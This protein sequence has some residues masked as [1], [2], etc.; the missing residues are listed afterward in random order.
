ME[1][2]PKVNYRPHTLNIIVNTSIDNNI[3]N[4]MEWLPK[5]NYRPHTLNIIVNTS[6]DNNIVNI[7]KWLPECLK[8]VN[9]FVNTSI[10]YAHMFSILVNPTAC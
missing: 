1:W 7:I 10:F 6:I 3:V 8:T 5:V 2:L 4:I 9:T